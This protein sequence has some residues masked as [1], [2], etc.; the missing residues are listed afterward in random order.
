MC[1]CAKHIYMADKGQWGGGVVVCFRMGPQD[2]TQVVRL[3]ARHSVPPNHLSSHFSFLRRGLAMAG[4]ELTSNPP[5]SVLGFRCTLGMPPTLPLPFSFLFSLLIPGFL[6][7]THDPMRVG[8]LFYQRVTELHP[9][10]V[11]RSGQ[12]GLL[13]SSLLPTPPS[14]AAGDRQNSST[15]LQPQ[16]Q[17]VHTDT[18]NSHRKPARG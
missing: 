4:L 13:A 12:S 9:P 5:A 6:V 1:V 17:P 8:W 3:S 15:Q 2:P 11:G 18:A 10:V 16:P 14:L 7:K